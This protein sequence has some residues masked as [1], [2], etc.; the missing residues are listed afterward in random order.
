M[1]VQLQASQN[2]LKPLRFLK[3]ISILIIPYKMIIFIFYD[4]ENN[5]HIENTLSKVP[6]A[7]KITPDYLNLSGN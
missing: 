7:L 5:L 6:H 4:E 2:C 3:C 1:M